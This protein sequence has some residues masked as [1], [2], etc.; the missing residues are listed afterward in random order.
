MNLAF[1][2][3]PR[4]LTS[5]A[6]YI[7]RMEE[8]S[9]KDLFSK[10]IY[11]EDKYRKELYDHFLNLKKQWLENTK[12]SSNAFLNLNHPAHSEILRYGKPFL[13][14]IL[15]DLKENRNHW[16]Y[17]LSLISGE[18]PV[19]QE[20]KGNVERMSEDWIE[21]GKLNKFID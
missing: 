18:D 7:N 16:F 6:R 8:L 1:K 21:W 10:S 20:N 15:E 12:F 17:T 4:H 3:K 19:L 14:F 11:M 5:E 13:P 9:Y 2:Q